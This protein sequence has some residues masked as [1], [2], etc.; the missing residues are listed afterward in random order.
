V[1][2]SKQSSD[3]TIAALEQQVATLNERH[4]LLVQTMLHGV[5]RH[6]ADGVIVEMNAAAER[7]LGK[8]ADEL[9][10]SSSQQEAPY[11]VREDGTVF[12]AEEP[13]NGCIAHWESCTR[14]CDGRG[15]P[16]F[17]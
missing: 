14:C 17:Y 16:K 15:Q 11:T 10:G 1:E 2:L 9:V 8:N 7:I 6:S 3:E 13:V 12:P 4:R 5:V